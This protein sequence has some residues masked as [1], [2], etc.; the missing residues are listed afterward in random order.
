MEGAYGRFN[1][2]RKDEKMNKFIAAGFPHHEAEELQKFCDK[3]GVPEEAI[4][5]VIQLHHEPRL[6]SSNRQKQSTN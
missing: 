2:V 4:I 1:G 3:Y 5:N 6:N